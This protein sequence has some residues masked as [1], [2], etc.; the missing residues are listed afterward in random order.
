MKLYGYLNGMG[1]VDKLNGRGRK[2][3]KLQEIEFTL[4]CI[5]AGIKNYFV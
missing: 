2:L 3:M 5:A 1:Y 4:A